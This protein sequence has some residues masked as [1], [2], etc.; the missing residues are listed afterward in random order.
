MSI[1]P[2]SLNCKFQLN[3]ICELK[4]PSAVSLKNEKCPHFVEKGQRIKKKNKFF[5]AKFD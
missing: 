1:I 3:G 5:I 2:C 4:I